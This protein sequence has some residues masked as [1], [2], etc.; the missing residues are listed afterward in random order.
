[1]GTVPTPENS[2]K[3]TI[4]HEKAELRILFDKFQAG[5]LEMYK[6]VHKTVSKKRARQIRARNQKTNI[7]QPDFTVGDIV[8]VQR[9]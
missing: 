9:T 5:I 7:V 1:M 6:R 4:D 8:L 2:T 3:Q